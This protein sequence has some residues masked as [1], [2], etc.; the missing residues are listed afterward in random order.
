MNS[1][2]PNKRGSW[3]RFRLRTLVLAVAFVAILMVAG[4]NFYDWYTSTPLA[5]SV[6]AFNARAKLDPIEMHEPPIT[7]DEIVLA[8]ES[9]LPTLDA[10]DY[11]KAVSSRIARTRRLPRGASLDSIPGYMPSPGH[12]YTVWWINL[13]I[14]TGPKSGYAMRIRETDNPVAAG[15]SRRL[16]RSDAVHYKRTPR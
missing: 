15:D 11:V 13:N 12:R 8:I 3:F 1:D 4:R 14:I 6:F 16:E 2:Q 7:E 5:E 10:S 9:Q